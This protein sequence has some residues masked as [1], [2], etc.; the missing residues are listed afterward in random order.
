[1]KC[2]QKR[3]NSTS[4]LSGEVDMTFV[5]LSQGLPFIRS[6]K[7]RILGVS[8]AKRSTLASDFPT[9]AESVPGF[10][11]LSFYGLVA[12]VK[13]PPSIL[14]RL[15][16]VLLAAATSKEGR[17]RMLS[18][19]LEPAGSSPEEFGAFIRAQLEKIKEAVQVSGVRIE[20]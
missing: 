3:V 8:S 20:D 13:T 1:M 15:N 4:T 12:P 7:L 2:P 16:Q 14:A 5:A 9:I 18:L 19:G 10:D 17:E 6:G 11:W